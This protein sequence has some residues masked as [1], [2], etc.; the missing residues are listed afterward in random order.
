M[1]GG[2]AVACGGGARGRD[3]WLPPWGF[4]LATSPSEDCGDGG[5]QT[6]EA[7]VIGLRNCL[8]L[9]VTDLEPSTLIW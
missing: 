4:R 9:F 7:G 2:G 8:F 6:S 1:K 3:P 5:D